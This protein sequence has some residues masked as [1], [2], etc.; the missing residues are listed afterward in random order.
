MS[1]Y[2]VVTYIH[3]LFRNTESQVSVK[4][5]AEKMYDGKPRVW[6]LIKVYI[7]CL[8]S[9]LFK[10]NTRS[11]E[12]LRNSKIDPCNTA[13]PPNFSQDDPK[14]FCCLAE[15]GIKPM[16][17][18]LPC[19]HLSHNRSRLSVSYRSLDKLWLRQTQLMQFGLPD[20]LAEEAMHLKNA[21]AI[22]RMVSD[23]KSAMW[24]ENPSSGFPTR[25][26]KTRQYSHRRWLE[27]GNFGFSK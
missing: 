12:T 7:D 25:S 8:Q 11:A 21:A 1:L 6:S 18:S 22:I 26:E 19:K 14:D 23:V 2:T 10:M 27:A 4:D 13:I 16:T 17:L 3:I 5:L 20:G 15:W 9:F 24:R